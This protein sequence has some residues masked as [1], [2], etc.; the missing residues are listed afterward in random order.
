[1]SERDLIKDLLEQL[2]EAGAEELRK[3]LKLWQQKRKLEQVIMTLSPAQMIDIRNALLN[4]AKDANKTT[5]QR[6][7]TIHA[8]LDALVDMV[9]DAGVASLM[10]AIK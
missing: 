5:A 4:S 7:R 2:V 10:G 3:A 1:M 6:N 9:I 8:I